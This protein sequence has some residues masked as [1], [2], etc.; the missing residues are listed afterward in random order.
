MGG[1][2]QLGRAGSDILDAGAAALE[3][4]LRVRLFGELGCIGG[5]ISPW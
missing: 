4:G 5:G 1:D 3:G 2:R